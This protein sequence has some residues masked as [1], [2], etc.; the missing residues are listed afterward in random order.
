MYLR[1]HK[2]Y[3]KNTPE[4][5]MYSCISVEY[6]RHFRIRSEYNRIRVEY[7]ILWNTEEYKRNTRGIHRIPY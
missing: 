6:N 3:D 4:Y 5:K 1:I 7:S 2:E